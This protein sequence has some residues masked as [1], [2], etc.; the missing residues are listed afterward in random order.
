MELVVYVPEENSILLKYNP[1]E[2]NKELKTCIPYCIMI[3]H[4]QK[5]LLQIPG[6]K[7]DNG[8]GLM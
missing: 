5:N 7:V 8:G 1:N 4:Y 6:G 3:H 2:R